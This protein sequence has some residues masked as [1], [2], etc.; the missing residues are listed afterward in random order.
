MKVWC[1]KWALTEGILELEVKECGGVPGMVEI[2]PTP[3]QKNNG[4]TFHSYLHGEGKDWHREELPALNRT[5]EM[6][7]KK[8]KALIRQTSKAKDFAEAMRKRRD[9]LLSEN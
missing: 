9:Q 4:F 3:E 2:I 1:T 7:D 6:A 8:V 5:I